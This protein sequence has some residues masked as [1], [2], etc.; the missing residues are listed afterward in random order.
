ML[1][2]IRILQHRDRSV[3][4]VWPLMRA[5]KVRA[6]IRHMADRKRAAT[7]GPACPADRF[8]YDWGT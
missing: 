7:C 4:P 6:P 1:C 2:H 5:Q 8:R 3:P